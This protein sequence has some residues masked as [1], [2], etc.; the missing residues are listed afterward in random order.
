MKYLESE[1]FLVIFTIIPINHLIT[2]SSHSKHTP[3]VCQ[4]QETI[5]AWSSKRMLFV[6]EGS[7]MGVI[8]TQAVSICSV[9]NKIIHH[10][11]SH[12]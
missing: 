9:A 12:L 2:T 6:K 4:L 3:N 5:M 10:H 1:A 8:T 11:A 7:V